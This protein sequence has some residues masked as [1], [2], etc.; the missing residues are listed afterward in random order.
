MITDFS[1]R[2]LQIQAKTGSLAC[3][4]T[5]STLNLPLPPSAPQTF[6]LDNVILQMATWTAPPQKIKINTYL[7]LTLP[8][9]DVHKIIL[10]IV[11]VGGQPRDVTSGNLLEMVSTCSFVMEKNGHSLPRKRNGSSPPCV[12]A[13]A[14]CPQVGASICNDPT[15]IST[16]LVGINVGVWI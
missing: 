9:L 13:M 8:A 4:V 15:D 10:T 14:S 1:Q 12:P 7:L 16:S 6:P 5:K 3:K 11:A 2:S